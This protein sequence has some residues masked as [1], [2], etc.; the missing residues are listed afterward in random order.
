MALGT[1]GRTRQGWK[2]PRLVVGDQARLA[3]ARESLLERAGLDAPLAAV[4]GWQSWGARG[5]TVHI[6]FEDGHGL[7][8][9]DTLR[10]LG[11]I[12]GEVRDVR[13]AERGQGVLED[14]LEGETRFETVFIE[15]GEQRPPSPPP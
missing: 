9:G 10:H 4:L 1:C 6:R 11:I 15:G 2:P 7:R 3:R 14:F 5:T 12:A 13:Y 8:T